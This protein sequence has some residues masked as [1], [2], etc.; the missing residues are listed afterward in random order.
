M[1]IAAVKRTE[2]GESGRSWRVLDRATVGGYRGC[3]RNRIGDTD[4]LER[5]ELLRRNDRTNALANRAIRSA[6]RRRFGVDGLVA[7]AVWAK[8]R[9]ERSQGGN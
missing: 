2:F 8:E 7:A 1:P 9:I 5:R 6:R 4:K 3:R